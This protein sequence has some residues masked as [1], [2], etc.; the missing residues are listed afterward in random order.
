MKFTIHF[1]EL[2]FKNEN[3]LNTFHNEL[4]NIIYV[5]QENI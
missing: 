2:Y 5:M 1:E 4:K 3:R